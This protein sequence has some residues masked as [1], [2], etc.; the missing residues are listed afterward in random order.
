MKKLV[1]LLMIALFA[2]SGV[3]AQQRQQRERSTPEE[4]AKRQTETLTKELTLTDAQKDKVY[5]IVLKFSQPQTQDNA[6]TDRE[7]RREEFQKIQ[8]QRNDSIKT[9]LTDDQKKK[10]DKHIEDMQKRMREN[11]RQQ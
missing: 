5:K 2:T 11:R 8:K 4:R 10:F 1:L 3:F 6:N 7:K 9:V